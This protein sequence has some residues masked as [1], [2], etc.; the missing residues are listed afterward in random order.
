MRAATPID[1]NQPVLIPNDP[2]VEKTSFILKMVSLFY[3]KS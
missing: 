3:Q 1:P 2:E